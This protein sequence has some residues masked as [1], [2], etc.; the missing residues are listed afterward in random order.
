MESGRVHSLFLF[1]CFQA[2]Y[3]LTASGNVFRV[4][5]EFEVYFQ[6]EHLVDA[7]DLS[8]PQTLILRQPVI[9]NGQVVGQTPLFFGKKGRDGKPYAPYGPLAAVLAL[10]HH[11]AGRAIAT[12]VGVP[13]VP[14]PAPEAVP[15]TMLVGAIT[16]LA[17]STAAALAI[18]GFYRAARA[19][20][21]DA[22]RALTL[23]VLLGAAT[24]LWEYGTVFYAEAF[25]AAALIWSAAW[26]LAARA[27]PRHAT[28][29]VVAAATLLAVA[30]LSKPTAV[31]FTPA[32]VVGVLAQPA[33]SWR[34]R[35]RV[36][37]VLAAGIG[38][39]MLCHAWW[40]VSRF[41][42]PFDL[43]YD[44]SETIPRPPFR[45]FAIE[46]L[47]RGLAI[48]L[49]SPGKSLF[50]WVPPLIL[51]L[52]RARSLARAD[53]GLA[54]A[55][56]AGLTTALV[57]YGS[58]LFP[59]GGY[60]Y[61]P[62]HLVP[63]VPL[64]MLAAAHPATRPLSRRAVLACGAP[65][66]VLALLAVSTSFL[67]DQAL[68]TTIP[69]AG[70][71]GYYELIDPAPGRAANRYLPGY[72]PFVRALRSPA[73][74]AGTKVGSG[75]DFLPYL[76]VTVRRLV[77]GG[78]AIPAWLPYAW[79]LP[80]L[81]LLAWSSARLLRIHEILRESSSGETGPADRLGRWA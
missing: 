29:L 5:D 58:Y 35:L 7:G 3:A 4:P 74:S 42:S 64:L 18:A 79:P 8:V 11:L 59:E 30:I 76:L 48:L 70:Q 80:F 22:R 66:A 62:R 63:L 25:V 10:P 31:V 55:L 43:G 65:G 56:L 45:P 33:L 23:S 69:G 13:R 47:P 71:V 6:V 67:D 81:L 60:A 50:V 28:P 9:V 57:F 53:R 77:P 15:W 16:S 49:F 38:V 21:A 40:N 39:A 27:T 1:L 12:L 44:W 17:P 26:L 36:G 41:G 75:P 54:A 52:T 73:W 24:V 61:G 37:A 72:V 46:D 34:V 32:F 2:L 14:V 19:L 51:A 78:T 68:G 20:G